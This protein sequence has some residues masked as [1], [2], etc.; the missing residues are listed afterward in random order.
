MT[1]HELWDDQSPER[2]PDY[3]YETHMSEDYAND[4]KP[5]QAAEWIKTF[6][7]SVTPFVLR[8]TEDVT[9][10]SGTGVV[11]DGV[12]FPDMKTVTRWR[13]GTSGIAQTCVWDSPHHVKRIHGHNGATEIEMVPVGDLMKALLAALAVEQTDPE[14]V[15]EED[16]DAQRGWNEAVWHL[17]DEICMALSFSFNT[18]GPGSKEES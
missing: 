14:S 9:G 3:E 12:I 18:F 6:T 1:D 2:D 7:N 16:R 10:V 17:Q 8:R 4:P 11:A 15:A 5:A 13:G